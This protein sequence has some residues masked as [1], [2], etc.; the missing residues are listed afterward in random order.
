MVDYDNNSVVSVGNKFT[1]KYVGR[2]KVYVYCTDEA[3]NSD[4]ASFTVIVE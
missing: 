3:G 1:A 2:Y 4:Y